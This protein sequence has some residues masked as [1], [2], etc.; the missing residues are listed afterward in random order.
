MKSSNLN[1]FGQAVWLASGLSILGLLNG[2]A[3]SLPS[4]LGDQSEASYGF[5]GTVFGSVHCLSSLGV[6]FFLF[7]AFT[8]GDADFLPS[9]HTLPLVFS[10]LYFLI[11]VL[12]CGALALANWDS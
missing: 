3:A 12:M 1:V 8:K 4:I 5:S 7:R 9:R 6:G 2:L 10:A 11:V